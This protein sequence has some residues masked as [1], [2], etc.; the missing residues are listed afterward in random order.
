MR[1]QALIGLAVVEHAVRAGVLASQQRRPA[2]AADGDVVTEVRE[3]GAPNPCLR[4]GQDWPIIGTHVIGQENQH[5]WLA[6]RRC[7][8]RRVSMVP[9]LV[10][11]P[12]GVCGQ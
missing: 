5:V 11:L 3:P 8:R 2:G 7:S 10:V 9:P 4:L 12:F 1:L 6:S